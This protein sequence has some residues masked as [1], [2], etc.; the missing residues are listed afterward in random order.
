MVDKPDEWLIAENLD[1]TRQYVVHA[2]PPR[3]IGEFLHTYGGNGGYEIREIDWI[4]PLPDAAT[5]ARLMREAID[6][7]WRYDLRV[8]YD[9]EPDEEE[10]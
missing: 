1:G 10:P 8:E 6:A 4:N 9:V 3:F 7:I 5:V 2:S